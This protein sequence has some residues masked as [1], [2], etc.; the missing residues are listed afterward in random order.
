MCVRME[1]EMCISITNQPNPT[2]K[3]KTNS[4]SIKISRNI[5]NLLF[6]ESSNSIK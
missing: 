5:P 4:N 2:I 6:E 3:Q 1:K